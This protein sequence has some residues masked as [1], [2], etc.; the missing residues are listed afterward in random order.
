MAEF[1]VLSE[2]GFWKADISA[3]DVLCHDVMLTDF[4]CCWLSISD[5]YVI[6]QIMT[7]IFNI[8]TWCVIKQRKG[9]TTAEYQLHPPHKGQMAVFSVFNLSHTHAFVIDSRTHTSYLIHLCSVCSPVLHRDSIYRWRGQLQC[10]E[11]RHWD[12][13][14]FYG[15]REKGLCRQTVL[16]RGGGICCGSNS[17]GHDH[18]L[19]KQNNLSISGTHKGIYC[20][21]QNVAAL[22]RSLALV[23]C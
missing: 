22:Q 17:R 6:L 8:L 14:Q 11:A 9:A 10:E 23:C 20:I 4:Y 18:M 3:R 12:I 7:I 19:F 13:Q 16:A 2:E 5:M 21:R 1:C 15:R